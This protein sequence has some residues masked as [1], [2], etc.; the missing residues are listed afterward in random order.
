M[1][2]ILS[3]KNDTTKKRHFYIETR[4]GD[5]YAGPSRWLCDPDYAI[6]FDTREEAEET[7]KYFCPNMTKIVEF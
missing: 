6:A 2:V 5:F 1:M 3:D 7:R 4:Q